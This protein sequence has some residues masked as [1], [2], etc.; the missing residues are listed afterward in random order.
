MAS[1][2]PECWKMFEKKTNSCWKMH[3]KCLKCSKQN[4]EC[5]KL[6]I[7]FLYILGLKIYLPNKNMQEFFLR[8]LKK[9]IKFVMLQIKNS[10]C[11]KID[12]AEIQKKK[13]VAEKLGE[14]FNYWK[15]Q[16]KI[17]GCL[18]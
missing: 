17:C 18:K 15:M 12:G 2:R 7:F 13:L 3:E 1:K 9:K 4:S 6:Q 5:L 14:I 10:V 11:K 8:L 16:E